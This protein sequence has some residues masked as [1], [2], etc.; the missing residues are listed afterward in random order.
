MR[1]IVTDRETVLDARSRLGTVY[2]LLAEVRLAPEGLDLGALTTVGA[3]TRE[4]DPLEATRQ[5]WAEVEGSAPPDEIDA[6]L[7]DAL[8]TAVE[9]SRP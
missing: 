3:A 4:L 5:F 6:L 1:A 8:R 2:P 9:R 7:V